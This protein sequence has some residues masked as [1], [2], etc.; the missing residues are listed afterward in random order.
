MRSTSSTSTPI[1]RPRSRS[2]PERQR[3]WAWISPPRH[4]RAAAVR[5]PS[6]AP[7][8]PTTAWPPAPPPRA[9]GRRGGGDAPRG[10]A[11]PHPG[12]DA[13]AGDRDRDAGGEVAI[14]DELD[15]G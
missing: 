13:G 5:T 10:A 4:L 8:A 14:G 9:R 2:S 6:G 11:G 3:N 7:P 1:L 15:A 12:V